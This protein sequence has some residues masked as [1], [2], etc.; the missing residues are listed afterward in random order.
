MKIN[1]S[2]VVISG[3]ASGMG[4]ATARTLSKLGA[5][6]AILDREI[7]KANIIATDIGGLAFACD[8]TK[9]DQVKH[10]I[11]EIINA[12]GIP[13]ACIN[14]AGIIISK[15]MIGKDGLMP[16]ADF[17]KTLEVNV[18]GT[19][20]LMRFAA[21]AMITNDPRGNSGERGVIINTASIAA[22]EGQI[23]QVAYS[24]SK[25]AIVSM[26]LPAA[27]ELAQ[28]GVRVMTIAP[29][30][31]DTP[32]FANLPQA[33]R[34]ALA[35]AVPFPK[36]LADPYEYAK[37]AVHIIKNEMLNGEVIRLDGALRMQ[38]K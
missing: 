33:A 32:M 7:N 22:F 37:L 2:V 9:E 1:Q 17:Q 27:R 38:P 30:L 24:A 18:M 29:G 5:K 14:C 19:F 35:A 31:V 8:V 28:F 23:G 36:R 13:R 4:E 20:N 25:G 15:R 21:N 10:A 3:G 6:V 26:T 16:L 11:D 34:D 12:I